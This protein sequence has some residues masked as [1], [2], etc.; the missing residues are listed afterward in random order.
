MTMHCILQCMK[1][2]IQLGTNDT[3]IAYQD[4]PTVKVVICRNN[5]ILTM[6]GGTLPGGG[7]ESGETKKTALAREIREE[8]GAT[9]QN[10]Q[11]AGRVIQYRDYLRKRYVV[12]GYCASLHSVDT[13]MQKRE[14]HE[15]EFTYLWIDRKEVIS[16]IEAAISEHKSHHP[17]LINDTQQGRLYNLQTSL[18][19]VSKALDIF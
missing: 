7:V 17:D 14:A 11:D 16:Y 15:K 3:T 18:A 4:R 5:E 1:R 12:Y 2:I 8:I 10:I 19:I 6:N 13:V 9:V